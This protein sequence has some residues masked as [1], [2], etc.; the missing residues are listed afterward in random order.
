[1]NPQCLWLVHGLCGTDVGAEPYNT[2]FLAPGGVWQCL[3]PV[4]ETS[5]FLLLQRQRRD[6]TSYRRLPRK[7][8]DPRATPELF[9][10]IASV[11]ISSKQFQWEF[12]AFRASHGPWENGISLLQGGRGL[13]CFKGTSSGGDGKGEWKNLRSTYSP[14]D[15]DPGDWV[16]AVEER[17]L[18][19][20]SMPIMQGISCIPMGTFPG[21]CV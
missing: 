9:H 7:T 20:F 21:L 18:D 10:V 12:L 5:L 15:Q 3:F 8:F 17:I 11:F 14:R 2:L 19:P 16:T 13:P 6:V 1:M 4:Q